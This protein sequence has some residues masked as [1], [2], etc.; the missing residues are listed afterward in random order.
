MRVR[1]R[2]AEGGGEKEE[3][4]IWGEGEGEEKVRDGE[5]KGKRGREVWGGWEEEG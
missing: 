5:G 1:V 4:G 3:G 2:G